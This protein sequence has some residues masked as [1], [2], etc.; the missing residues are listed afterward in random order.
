MRYNLNSKGFAVSPF[1]IVALI[2]LA[3]LIV[4]HLMSIDTSKARSVAEESEVNKAILNLEEP[5]SSLKTFTL[6]SAHQAAYD[7]GQE[8]IPDEGALINKL[9]EDITD[10]LKNFNSYENLAV[11]GSFTV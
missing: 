4:I 9:E 3:V 11:A 1:F 2:L 5:K 7:A 6:L 10:D 8:G